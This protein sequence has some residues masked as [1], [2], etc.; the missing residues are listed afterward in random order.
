MLSPTGAPSSTENEDGERD[1]EMHQT[2][3]ASGGMETRDWGS[4]VD[5]RI[6]AIN[7]TRSRVRAKVGHTI[8]GVIERVFGVQKVRY[9]GV[10][11]NLQRLEVT[12]ALANQVP[13]PPVM[14]V[15]AETDVANRRRS[16]GGCFSF[17]ARI[18]GVPN[19]ALSCLPQSRR[20]IG[21]QGGIG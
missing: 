12:A 19:S 4:R 11:K 2:A 20:Q 9:R 14:H 3:K 7:R 10:A 1:P 13:E 6:K 5:E 18:D 21:T 17:M 8:G 16:A 15:S